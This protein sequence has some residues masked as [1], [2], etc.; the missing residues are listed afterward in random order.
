MKDADGKTNSV[1]TDQ[2]APSGPAL[3]SQTKIITEL[4]HQQEATNI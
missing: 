1:E 3:F 2:T 4:L